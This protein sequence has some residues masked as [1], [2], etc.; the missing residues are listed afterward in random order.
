M[1]SLQE[2]KDMVDEMLVQNRDYL[3][4]FKSFRS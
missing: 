3:P 4:Q 2:I 1:L